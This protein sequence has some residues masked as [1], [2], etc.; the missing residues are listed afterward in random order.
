M[1]NLLQK[2]KREVILTNSQTDKKQLII[3][4]YRTNRGID[5]LKLLAYFDLYYSSFT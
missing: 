4:L 5:L 1:D 2:L 3:A